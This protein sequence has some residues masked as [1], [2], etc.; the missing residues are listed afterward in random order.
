VV[1]KFPRSASA[2]AIQKIAQG[3]V[4]KQTSNLYQERVSIK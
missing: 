4:R 3:I 1:L 2:I